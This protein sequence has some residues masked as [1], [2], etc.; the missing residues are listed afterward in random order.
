MQFIQ[1]TNKTIKEDILGQ[2]NALEDLNLSL[3]DRV[4]IISCDVSYRYK[5]AYSSI[6]R[7]VNDAFVDFKP[8]PSIIEEA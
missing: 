2:F 7:M 3:S 5:I 4:K 8:Q 6:K 1:N